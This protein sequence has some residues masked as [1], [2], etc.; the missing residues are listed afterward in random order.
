MTRNM[1][2]LSAVAFLCA[3]SSAAMADEFRGGDGR[4]RRRYRRC[5]G[6]RTGRRDRWRRRRRR[7]R[8]RRDQSS[9]LS[10]RLRLPALPPPLAALSPGLRWLWP[11]MTK[12]VQERAGS[13][14]LFL[15]PRSGALLSQ[16]S[17]F[18][19]PSDGV[20]R[21]FSV[22]TRPLLLKPLHWGEDR[23][24][25]RLPSRRRHTNVTHFAPL[26]LRFRV[27]LGSF[28][29]ETKHFRTIFSG[30]PA[31]IDAIFFREIGTFQRLALTFPS[32][33]RAG[34]GRGMAERRPK[35]GAPGGP[36]ERAAVLAI[37]HRQFSGLATIRHYI[38]K[39]GKSEIFAINIIIMARPRSRWS[40]SF[41][42]QRR[43]ERLNGRMLRNQ[44]RFHHGRPTSHHPSCR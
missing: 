44:Q 42:R 29:P 31:E 2:V 24:A 4:R 8:Q 6:W 43:I 32:G 9:L 11:M 26:L 36:C 30:K 1:L 38:D 19:T 15:G 33:P 7:R 5:G 16:L 41:A 17:I 28:G 18:R 40:A 22:Q 21:A 25:G 37:S 12:V 10:P 13:S 14:G 27:Q 35:H 39:C 20:P 3:A 34:D 23:I